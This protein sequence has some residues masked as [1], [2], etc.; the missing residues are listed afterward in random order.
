MNFYL[1]YGVG[2]KPSKTRLNLTQNKTIKYNLQSRIGK[3]PKKRS[4]RRNNAPPEVHAPPP[5]ANLLQQPNTTTH[6]NRGGNVVNT[7]GPRSD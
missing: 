5:P 3:H 1:H 6:G 7:R 4:Y 2:H